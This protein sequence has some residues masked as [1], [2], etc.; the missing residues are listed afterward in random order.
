MPA[1][2]NRSDDKIKELFEELFASW[3]RLMEMQKNPLQ[4]AYESFGSKSNTI[5][6][7]PVGNKIQALYDSHII[8]L[9][10][11]DNWEILGESANA[12][13]LRKI[14]MVDELVFIGHPTWA[15]ITNRSHVLTA[16]RGKQVLIVSFSHITKNDSNLGSLTQ[17]LTDETKLEAE[18]IE[19]RDPLIS[20]D[21]IN[22]PS[23][24]NLEEASDFALPQ[25]SIPSVTTG[26][27]DEDEL[28]EYVDS[29][30][31]KLSDDKS[32]WW[33]ATSGINTIETINSGDE[34]IADKCVNRKIDEISEGQIVI[35]T[36]T[37]AGDITEFFA[38][39]ILGDKMRWC[40][41]LQRNWK[42]KLRSA[43]RRLGIEM[44]VNHI[45]SLEGKIGPEQTKSYSNQNNLKNWCSKKNI[46]PLSETTFHAI[47]KY[48]SLEDELDD[49]LEASKIMR[50]AHFKAGFIIA[51]ATRK[52]VKGES[53]KKLFEEE[54]Q[55]FYFDM[56]ELI[57]I[58]GVNIDEDGD[59]FN[60]FEERITGHSDHDPNDK[61][62]REEVDQ[63]LE[64]I[65][66]SSAKQTAFLVEYIHREK[67]SVPSQQVGSLNEF[68]EVH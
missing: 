32:I 1:L 63:A 22:I 5:F 41:T 28:Q 46:S 2:L 12:S 57:N 25:L 30:F 3:K 29:Y 9:F 64:I 45:Q 14:S 38:N 24:E 39:N 37:G 68:H 66:S 48:C 23:T 10:E 59:G 50:Q 6:Y 17:F 20:E 67:Q 31:I 65:K 62:T 15:F 42:D 58:S 61:P 26:E 52:S 8:S 56:T 60:A 43:V 18:E 51:K 13:R 47:L 27:K 54:K 34:V 7:N 4:L 11:I 33:S 40:R 35:L 36:T 49:Y 44:V 21:P 16:P 19:F 55:D 53:L